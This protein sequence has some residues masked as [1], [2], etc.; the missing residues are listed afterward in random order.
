MSSEHAVRVCGVS[1]RYR[2][3]RRPA[4]R[5]IEALSFGRRPRHAVVEAL[6]DVSFDVRAG[7][8]V[9]ILGRNGSG[10][11]TLLAIV[12]GTVRPSEGRVE[13]RGRVAALLELGTSF[14][15]EV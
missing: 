12:T 8:C 5:W 10:K 3:Y 13:R 15:P 2:Q 4:D 7:E 1:K 11:S 6:R 9:G 14:S